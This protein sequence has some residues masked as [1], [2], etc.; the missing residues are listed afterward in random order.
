M[1]PYVFE[2]KALYKN[3]SVRFW[4]IIGFL[5]DE[6]HEKSDID[7]LIEAKPSFIERYGIKSI[8]Q[9]EEIKKEMSSVLA[10]L[11]I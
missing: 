7:I 3:Y 10:F 11:F 8:E 4:K 2:C 9:I 1:Y 5:H 6:A